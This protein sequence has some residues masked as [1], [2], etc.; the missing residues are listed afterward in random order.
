VPAPP[1]L[2]DRLILAMLNECVACLR[3]GIV[4]DADLLDAGVIF[5][6]GFAPFRG[7]PMHYARARGYA[8][9]HRR[10]VEFSSRYGQRF[11]P[12]PGWQALLGPAKT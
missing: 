2:I 10:L 7:G 3:E 9:I 12:D 8:E 6:S 4:E 1:D 5:G 11:S